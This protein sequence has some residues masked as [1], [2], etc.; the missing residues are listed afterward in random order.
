MRYAALRKQGDGALCLLVLHD[1]LFR[2][3]TAKT[4]FLARHNTAVL[5][6]SQHRS[7]RFSCF[8]L[9]G[10][11]RGYVAG[12]RCNVIFREPTEVFSI[13]FTELRVVLAPVRSTRSD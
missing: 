12:M 7:T 6:A 2:F 5:G 13:I 4:G 8:G 9:V 1:M 3:R 11:N 10:V